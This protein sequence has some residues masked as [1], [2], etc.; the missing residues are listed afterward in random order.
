[1]DN[2]LCGPGGHP[3]PLWVLAY[4]LLEAWLGKGKEGS[5]GSVV[6]LLWRGFVLSVRFVV[7]KT[8]RRKT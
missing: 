2:L 8:L 7:R 6:A 4:A 1:M 3:S 5:A